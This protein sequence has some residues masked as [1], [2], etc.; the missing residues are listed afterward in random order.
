MSS[1]TKNVEAG[2]RYDLALWLVIVAIVLG[3]VY[4]NTQF[5]TV[6]VLIRAFAGI[7]LAGV[8]I[9][10][11]LQTVR[12]HGVWE[13]AKEARIE[14]RKVIWPTKQELTQTTIIV[15][16]AVIVVGIILWGIDSLFSWGI[17][18]VLS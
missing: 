3:G 1:V 16:I 9:A 15:V 18:S 11:A 5:V 6:N 10:I 13:L 2:N 14:V 4:A 12:G 8:A 7:A 17:Q